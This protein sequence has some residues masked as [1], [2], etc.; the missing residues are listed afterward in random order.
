[1]APPLAIL[2][3]ILASAPLGAL[4]VPKN[5]GKPLPKRLAVALS[6]AFLSAPALANEPTIPIIVKDTT[7]FYWQTVLA[8]AR[9]A[10]KDLGVNVPELGA[11]GESDVNDEIITLTDALAGKPVAI[12]I[13]PIESQALGKP[14][15]E[16]AKWTKIVGI[17]SAADSKSFASFLATDNAAGGRLAADA[18]AAAIQEKYG[19]AEGD[20]ALIGSPPG[21]G[22]DQ[23]AKGFKEEIAAKFPGLKIV[24]EKS[25]DG[26]ATAGF[27]AATDLIAADPGLRGLFASNLVAAKGAGQ[28]LVEGKKSDAIKAIGYDSDPQTI[29]YLEDGVLAGLVVQDPYRMGYEAIKTALAASKGEKVPATIDTG[30][31]LITKGNMSS[32]RSQELLDPKV[33]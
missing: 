26:Q 6:L 10:G 19:K 29:K 20:V 21:V 3:A 2:R 11:Q 4:S 27:K 16:A 5:W 30:A 1:L 17:D 7:S 33:K 31:N 12:V 24:A 13:A 32:T 18:L 25:A 28:A 14:I 8:G 23:R 22:V 15:D 9:R